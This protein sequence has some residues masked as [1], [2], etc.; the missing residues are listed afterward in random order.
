MRLFL[1]AL[2]ATA[3]WAGAYDA[4]GAAAKAKPRPSD[5]AI[6]VDL[7][8]GMTLFS[9]R[10]ADPVNANCLACHSTE[11]ITTQPPQSETTWGA[12]ITKMRDIYKAPILEAD[13]KPIIRYLIQRQAR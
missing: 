8:Q 11:M 13:V 5:R 1:K 12:E 10:G 4:A 6:H 3:L 9:G 7:P 2:I